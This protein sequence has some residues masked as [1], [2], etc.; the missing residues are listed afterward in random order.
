MNLKLVRKVAISLFLVFHFS[1]VLFWVLT[2]FCGLVASEP[3]PSN[4][5]KTFER[6][7]FAWIDRHKEAFIP[8]LFSRYIDVIGAHQYWDFFA[9]Q[10]PTIHRYIRVC[11][12]IKIN[13]QNEF[14]DCIDPLYKS[15]RGTL[16]DAIFSHDGEN[17]RSFRF[18]ENLIRLDR[19]DLYKA[20]NEYWYQLLKHENERRNG[21]VYLLRTEIPL[22][23]FLPKVDMQYQRK[24]K[25]LW[26]TPE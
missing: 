19:D 21:E 13:P 7:T 16:R 9:P 15:Y 12:D 24:D 11:R 23:P 22:H 5:F 17:S 20:F 3:A 1:A 2:P 25:I 18:S 10:A 14:I 6:A 4:L 8:K 26:M